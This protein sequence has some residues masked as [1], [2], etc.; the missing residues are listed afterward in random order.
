MSDPVQAAPPAV[1]AHPA[2][3]AA[4]P[5][6][7]AETAERLIE[8]VHPDAQP[9]PAAAAV[10]EEVRPLLHGHAAAVFDLARKVFSSPELKVLAPDVLDL[11]IG[12]AKIAGVALG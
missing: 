2:D 3:P 5:G 1:P 8:H 7:F 4:E 10:A 9:A 11:V 12:A 6:W